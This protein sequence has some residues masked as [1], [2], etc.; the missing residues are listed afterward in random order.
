MGRRTAETHRRSRGRRGWAV[1]GCLLGGVLAC[2]GTARAQ[3]LTAPSQT[4]DPETAKA[5]LARPLDVPKPT[6]ATG[7]RFYDG[8]LVVAP[9]L[10]L[11]G[12]S[13]SNLFQNA[14]GIAD[15]KAVV[16]PAVTVALDQGDVG[17]SL[18][19]SGRFG[20]Y[21]LTDALRQDGYLFG[22]S[23][24]ARLAEP[25]T[26]TTSFQ[27]KRQAYALSALGTLGAGNVQ[28]FV[29]TQTSRT[30]LSYESGPYFAEFVGQVQAWGQGVEGT[31]E[32]AAP[33]FANRYQ[34][35]EFNQ[36]GKVGLR[37]FDDATAYL[38]VAGNRIAYQLADG[39]DRDSRGAMV[40]LGLDLPVLDGLRTTGQVGYLTQ[41][42]ADPR[43]N[44]VGRLVGQATTT[45]Q[46]S[47]DWAWRG[48]WSRAAS[49]LVSP[50]IPAITVTSYGTAVTYQVD[51]ALSLEVRLERLIQAAIQLPITYRG[52]AVVLGGQYLVSERTALEFGY[53]FQRQKTTD[54][55]QNFREHN[56]GLGVTMKF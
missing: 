26:L 37:F 50:G 49:E 21:L 29:T 27:V 53:K 1:R 17:A 8:A 23:L 35:T 43:F 47:Q 16:A 10:S 33:A 20:R 30:A 48:Y 11:S 34:R 9:Q 46:M 54:G 39:Y 4:V 36:I 7:L 14:T 28:T 31:G 25:W 3:S 55:S 18:V 5:A 13:S 24:R 32:A 52:W 40:A 41:R 51:P 15:L 22:P 12:I 38:L 6:P 56:L 42:F 19:A 45:W 44:T 2:D